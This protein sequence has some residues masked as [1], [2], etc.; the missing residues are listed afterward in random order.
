MPTGFSTIIRDITERKKYERDLL[1]SEN[2]YDLVVRGMNLGLWDWD[3][4][5]GQ[6]Y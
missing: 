1:Q 3:V 5:T 2:R 6:M 4:A